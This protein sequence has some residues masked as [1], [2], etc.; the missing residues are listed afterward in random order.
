[1]TDL[2]GILTSGGLSL[3]PSLQHNQEAMK[4]LNQ[5]RAKEAQ[6][7]RP[8]VHAAETLALAEHTVESIQLRI[9]GAQQREQQWQ[10]AAAGLPELVR[11]EMP[12]AVDVD[13]LRQELSAAEA[14]LRDARGEYARACSLLQDAHN[15]AEDLKRRIYAPSPEPVEVD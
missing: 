7:E 4:A 9:R 5:L 12:P 10:H 8:A 3:A 1:M 15:A 2:T 13:A 14:N 11:S 6:A